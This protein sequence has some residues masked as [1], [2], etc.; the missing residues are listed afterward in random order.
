MQSL[1]R[2]IDE[3]L[4]IRSLPPDLSDPKTV[5]RLSVEAVRL[6]DQIADAWRLTLDQRCTLLGGINPSTYTR[7]AKNPDAVRLS[8]DELARAS[9]LVGIYR[10]L[11]T[12]YP[13]PVADDWMLIANQNPLFAGVSPYAHAARSGIVALADIRTLLDGYRGG[14]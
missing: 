1:V 7:R 3:S 8:V 14:R 13:D 2:A 9:Y 6:V 10:A 11:H 4:P 5:A 12:I